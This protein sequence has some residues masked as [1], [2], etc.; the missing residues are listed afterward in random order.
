MFS[1]RIGNQIQVMESENMW[2][3]GQAWKRRLR[4]IVRNRKDAVWTKVLMKK[5]A[6]SF[7]HV[8]AY[9]DKCELHE[10]SYDYESEFYDYS[11][12]L[13]E[14]YYERILA[15]NCY[16]AGCKFRYLKR[17]LN[18]IYKNDVSD[19]RKWCCSDL[20][21]LFNTELET[22][23]KKHLYESYWDEENNNK[24]VFLPIEVDF[25]MDHIFDKYLYKYE[26][27]DSNKDRILSV[28]ASITDNCDIYGI[29]AKENNAIVEDIK[30]E[31]MPLEEID[32]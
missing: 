26:Y 5:I 12:D 7:L 21:I 13:H 30:K 18:L 3:I 19:M 25:Y 11:D 2:Q 27:F 16:R 29:I 17:Y 6:E 8:M 10:W 9:S 15:R 4:F 31:N 22:E 20:A 28:L 14:A 32:F 1:K 23:Y 24:K